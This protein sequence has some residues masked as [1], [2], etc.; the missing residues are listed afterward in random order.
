MGS[1]LEVADVLCC[2]ESPTPLQYTVIIFAILTPV[3]I[4]VVGLACLRRENPLHQHLSNAT[5]IQ[6]VLYLFTFAIN[7]Y[8]NHPLIAATMVT[9]QLV[10]VL[11]FLFGTRFYASPSESAVAAIRPWVSVYTRFCCA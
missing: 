7:A 1:C 9:V 5:F 6:L 2:V 10:L 3:V 11:L 8:A 4:A